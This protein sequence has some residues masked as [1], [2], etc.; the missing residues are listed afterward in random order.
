MPIGHAIRGRGEIGVVVLH[1]WFGDHTLW[2]PTFPI[3]DENRFTYAF[4]DYR[5]YGS[6]RELN[7]PN[8]IAQIVED[9]L[10]LA[11]HLDWPSFAVVGH[12][13]GAFALQRI[14]VDHPERIW[15]GVCV[16]PVPATAVKLDDERLELFEAAADDDAARRRIVDFSTGKRLSPVWVDHIVRLSREV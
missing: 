16:A 10:E 6:S 1:G 11:D 2:E 14:A 8:T 9:T 5:G 12:S 7:G 15:G 13:M 4:V 3:L